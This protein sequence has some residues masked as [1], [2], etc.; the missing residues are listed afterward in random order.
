MGYETNSDAIA[1]AT[2][3]LNAKVV[4]EFIDMYSIMV[5]SLFIWYIDEWTTSGNFVH[6]KCVNDT[7]LLCKLSGK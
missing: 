2:V 6:A 1:I 7:D 4:F 5:L 3:K